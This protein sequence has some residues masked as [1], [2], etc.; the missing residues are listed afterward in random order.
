MSQITKVEA[1]TVDWCELPA[2]HEAQG[3]EDGIFVRTHLRTVAGPY[4]VEIA[5]DE[6]AV[7]PDG[8][9]VD[10][11]MAKVGSEWL[12]EPIALV[13]LEALLGQLEV[14]RRLLGAPGEPAEPDR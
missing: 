3:T 13:E 11:P 9:G 10:A 6:F 8:P 1:C 2:G 4:S 7:A 12:V 5:A 14:A